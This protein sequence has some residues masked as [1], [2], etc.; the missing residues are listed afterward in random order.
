MFNRPVTHGV[1]IFKFSEKPA[2]RA[3]QLD[4]VRCMFFERTDNDKWLAWGHIAI[5]SLHIEHKPKKAP[6][7]NNPISFNPDDWVTSGTYKV[8]EVYD[9]EYQRIFTEHEAPAAWNFFGDN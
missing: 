1:D 9:P 2:A 8:I 6:D 7:P 3:F 5:Q 4:P